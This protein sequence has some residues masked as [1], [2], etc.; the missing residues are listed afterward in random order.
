MLT[1]VYVRRAYLY[2]FTPN[3]KWVYAE[4][5]CIP[6]KTQLPIVNNNM[7]LVILIKPYEHILK[8]KLNY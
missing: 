1:S 6:S 5:P 7:V 3:G 8:K 2:N 4:Y